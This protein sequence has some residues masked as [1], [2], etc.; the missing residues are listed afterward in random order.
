MDRD[1]PE[2]TY[3]QARRAYEAGQKLHLSSRVYLVRRVPREPGES[4]VL[5][6][7]DERTEGDHGLLLFPDGRIEKK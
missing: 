1:W 5:W 4:F 7:A 2:V 3:E 6:I